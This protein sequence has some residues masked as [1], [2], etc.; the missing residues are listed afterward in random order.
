MERKS[1][2]QKELLGDLYEYS[3]AGTNEVNMWVRQAAEPEAQGHE[4]TALQRT[5]E[6]ERKAKFWNQGEFQGR[7]TERGQLCGENEKS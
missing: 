5:E 4:A 7:E 2:R 3:V 6:P 1:K